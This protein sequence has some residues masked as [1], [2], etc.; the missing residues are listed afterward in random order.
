MSVLTSIEPKKVMYYFGEICKIPHGTFNTKQISDYL[1]AFAKERG[2]EV[3]QDKVNN[4]IMKKGGSTGCE[5]SEPVIIQGHIDMVCEKTEESGHNFA[6][7]PLDIYIKDGYVRAKDTTLGG[8]DGIAVAFALAVLDSD[9]LAHPPIEAV[10]TVDEEVGMGG[11]NEID[12]SVLKGRMLINI[13]SDVEGTLLAGCAGGFRQNITVPVVRE[14]MTGTKVDIHIKGLRGGHSG[15]EI[16]Q[17]RGN[18]NK[19]MARLLN[20]LNLKMDASLITVS[21][22]TKDNVITPAATA[23]LLVSKELAESVQSAVSAMETVMKEE[24]GKDEPH[25]QITAELTED[26]TSD[27]LT[28]ESTDKIVFFLN[29]T[30]NGVQGLNRELKG[31]VDTSLNLGVVETREDAVKAGFLVRS[32]LESKKCEL[33]EI[34]TA[35][36]NFLGADYEITGEYPAW[37]YKADSTLRPIM[38]DTYRELFGKEPVITTIHAGLECGLFSGKKPDLDCVSFGPEMQ[39]IHSVDERLNIESTQ[40]MWEY[41]KAV[42]AKCK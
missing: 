30:P 4:V 14:Q 7:D 37:T 32:S 23:V 22:G 21:G 17:Q 8:D 29:N 40:R 26:Q 33:K 5:M 10:F 19:L 18:A 1:V 38:A 36:S 11:A 41:L 27:V 15:A 24:F 16:D 13:D 9:D 34:L 3:I 39:D 31:L 28:K 35:W 6:T 12:L 2:L 42:L 25:L 20:H